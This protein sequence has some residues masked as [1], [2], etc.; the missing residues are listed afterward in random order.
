MAADIC[1]NISDKI[2]EG[3]RFI[4]ADWVARDE[5]QSSKER[6]MNQSL[7]CKE[8]QSISD[9]NGCEHI[10]GVTITFEKYV[11]RYGSTTREKT[12][13]Y[14]NATGQYLFDFYEHCSWIEDEDDDDGYEST[15][16]IKHCGVWDYKGDEIVMKGVGYQFQNVQNDNTW[17][18]ES[19]ENLEMMKLNAEFERK[20]RFSSKLAIQRPVPF[21][22]P[23]NIS[24]KRKRREN[25]DLSVVVHF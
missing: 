24:Y 23:E 18:Y 20:Y 12:L 25:C 9:E 21:K 16:V 17:G 15:K 4:Y 2:F 6:R 10:I 13:L 19:D 3:D 1:G 11:G 7:F 22:N 14:L 8:L 5:E